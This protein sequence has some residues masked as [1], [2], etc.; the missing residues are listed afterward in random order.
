M[1]CSAAGEPVTSSKMAAILDLLKIRNIN[2][3]SEEIEKV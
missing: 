3:K 1:G 2:Q